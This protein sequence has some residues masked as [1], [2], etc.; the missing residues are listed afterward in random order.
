MRSLRWTGR[1]CRRFLSAVARPAA[2]PLVELPDLTRRGAR[3]EGH[4][5]VLS[6]R[7]PTGVA[8]VPGSYRAIMRHRSPVFRWTQRGQRRSVAVVT[9]DRT[10]GDRFRAAAIAPSPSSVSARRGLPLAARHPDPSPTVTSPATATGP[11]FLEPCGWPPRKR[12]P[13]RVWPATPRENVRSAHRDGHVP[14]ARPLRASQCR[15][16]PSRTSPHADPPA[17][18]APTGPATAPA[19]T[20]VLNWVH[21]SCASPKAPRHWSGVDC[22]LVTRVANRHHP[23]DNSFVSLR[24]L[25]HRREP[26]RDCRPEAARRSV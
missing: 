21:A 5:L 25:S 11:R 4:R 10:V 24:A 16:S 17:S 1:R 6:R 2:A 22:S 14:P 8:A 26:L 18:A 3:G 12:G 23:F 7:W 13:G 19:A 15:P 20:E 9:A